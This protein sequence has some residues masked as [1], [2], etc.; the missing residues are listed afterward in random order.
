MGN[1]IK[2]FLF[3]KKK[4]RVICYSFMIIKWYSNGGLL[5]P[6]SEDKGAHR[7]QRLEA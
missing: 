5:V 7:L 1:T 2:M 6:L 3:S 4:K